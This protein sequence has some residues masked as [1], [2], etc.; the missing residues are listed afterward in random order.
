MKSQTSQAV[1]NYRI[2]ELVTMVH[3]YRNRPS[4]MSVDE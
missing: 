3:K 2:R 4:G 1:R